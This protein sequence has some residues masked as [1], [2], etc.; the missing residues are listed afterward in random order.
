[1]QSGTRGL[2]EALVSR[3]ESVSA[4]PPEVVRREQSFANRSSFYILLREAGHRLPSFV[5]RHLAVFDPQRV[6]ARIQSAAVAKAFTEK[7]ME[8]RRGRDDANET[9]DLLDIM[10]G[11]SS[12]WVV[13]KPD[14]VPQSKRTAA[15]RKSCD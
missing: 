3:S 8:R 6:R 4:S 13:D 1:M 10:S 12:S 11:S 9:E 2:L 5:K 14:A 15:R 7:V